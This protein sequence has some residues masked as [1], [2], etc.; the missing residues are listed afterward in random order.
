MNKVLNVFV[1]KM[2]EPEESDRLTFAQTI[3]GFEL[4][5]SYRKMLM[6]GSENSMDQERNENLIDTRTLIELA[7]ERIFRDYLK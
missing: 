1:E 4:V 7:N 5:I 2:A 3:S 6:A